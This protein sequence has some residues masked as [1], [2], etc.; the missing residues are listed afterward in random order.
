LFSKFYLRTALGNA[1]FDEAFASVNYG[2]R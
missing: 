2:P 1:L